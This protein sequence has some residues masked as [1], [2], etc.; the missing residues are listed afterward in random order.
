MIFF[1]YEN[2]TNVSSQLN[3]FYQSSYRLEL[4]RRSLISN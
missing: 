2:K 3:F 4:F 1:Y